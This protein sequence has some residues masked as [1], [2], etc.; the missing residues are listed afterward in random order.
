VKRPLAVAF[1]RCVRKL[2]LEAGLTHEDLAEAGEFDS[3]YV[4]LLERGLRMPS[5]DVVFKLAKALR[6][7]AEFLLSDTRSRLSAAEGLV[8]LRNVRNSDN[9]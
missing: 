1:G 2:R 7:S 4:S 5:I 9:A 8:A 6:T 3:S